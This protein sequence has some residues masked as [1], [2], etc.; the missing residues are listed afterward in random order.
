MP[1]QALGPAVGIM[2][3]FQIL[4]WPVIDPAGCMDGAPYLELWNIWLLPCY[5]SN[6][7]APFSRYFLDDIIRGPSDRTKPS[8][9]TPLVILASLTR[10]SGPTHART[11][12]PTLGRSR[13][14]FDDAGTRRLICRRR[15]LCLG[16]GQT[17][18]SD[19]S[20]QPTGF[21]IATKATSDP[22]PL[23][24]F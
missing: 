14:P 20:T 10:P 16:G 7:A 5:F 1:H 17:L 13:A 4:A 24:L 12:L 8:A 6:P 21:L 23:F 2:W 19:R 22:P 3:V 9:S 15:L 18:E 11:Y